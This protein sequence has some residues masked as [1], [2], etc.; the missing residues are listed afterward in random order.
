M[1]ILD[2]S[3]AIDHLRGYS[4]ATAFLE[5][6]IQSEG[7]LVASELTR[8]ELL[9]GARPDEHGHLEDFFSVV[10]WAPVSE[11]IV[12]QAAVYARSYRKS[13]SGVGVVDYL[14]AGTA[15]V[16]DAE[17]LTTNLRHFPMFD[18]LQAPYPYQ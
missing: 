5:D 3:V 16:L 9:A 2:T 6:L 11:A 12:R 17:L 7:T 8:F 14:I 13:H 15:A 10:D 4:R 1:K 18:D